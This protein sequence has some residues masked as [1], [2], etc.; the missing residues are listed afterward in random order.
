MVHKSYR[1]SWWVKLGLQFLLWMSY[2]LTDFI[3]SAAFPLFMDS[4]YLTSL[5][6]LAYS[7]HSKYFSAFAQSVSFAENTLSPHL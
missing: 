3:L 6:F 2:T 1:N 5:L 7:K 4:L